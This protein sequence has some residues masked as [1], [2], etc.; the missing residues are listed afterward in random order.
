MG[1][2]WDLSLCTSPA[3]V[4]AKTYIGTKKFIPLFFKSVKQLVKMI[5]ATNQVQSRYKGTKHENYHIASHLTQYNYWLQTWQYQLEYGNIVLSSRV[6]PMAR[7]G[8]T[9]AMCKYGISGCLMSGFLESSPVGIIIHKTFMA[10]SLN[11]IA[12]CTKTA[13]QVSQLSM[14]GS[15]GTIYFQQVLG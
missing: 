10:F 1:P 12:T 14:L 2:P 8:E 3:K 13:I 5:T 4:S 15:K 7:R 6:M 11:L 9:I